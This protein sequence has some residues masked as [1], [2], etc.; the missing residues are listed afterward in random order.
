MKSLFVFLFLILLGLNACS[1]DDSEAQERPPIIDM[2]MHTGLPH[3]VPAGTPALCRPEPCKGDG[4]ATINSTELMEKTLEQMDRYNIIKGFLSGV[5]LS[6]VQEWS[7]AAPGRF[8]ASPFILKA[9]SSELEKL[10]PE[11]AAGRFNGM[12]EIGTQ[13][14]GVAPNDPSLEPYFNLA[15]ELDLPVLIHTLGIGPYMPHFRSAAGSPLL[16]EEVLT[17]HPKLRL[18]VENAG[19][20]YR[21]EMIAM[22]YQYPQLYA[23][24]S[25]ITWVIPR[26]AFYDY[27]QTFIRAGLGKR[28]MFGSDQMVWPEKIGVA[29]E[30]IEQAPFLTAEQK[31]DIFYNNAVRFLRLEEAEDDPIPRNEAA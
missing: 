27:L 28:L 8:I 9:E 20:P 31:R 1:Q 30:A 16:L 29:V 22:M 23:D 26:T 14:N 17:R 19:Y 12:G 11:Y 5:D 24:V 2:H 25:T 18:F 15:E 4:Q 3:E 10:R 21:D 6:A 7:K 13:L